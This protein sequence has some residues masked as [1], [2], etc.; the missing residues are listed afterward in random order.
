MAAR[1]LPPRSQGRHR[2][3]PSG[4][5]SC[6]PI[7]RATKSSSALPTPAS[8]SG[9]NSDGVLCG[10]SANN[11]AVGCG[12][13]GYGAENSYGH[14]DTWLSPAGSYG[15]GSSAA[16]VSVRLSSITRPSG[17]INVVDASYYGA[18]PDTA[19]VTG[20]EKNAKTDGDS[21]CAANDHNCSDAA[22][23]QFQG[24]QY[25]SYWKNLGNANWSWGD[26]TPTNLGGT[27]PDAAAPALIQQ[28]HFQTLNCLFADGHVKAMQWSQVVGDICLWAT[29][30][31]GNH[32]ACQ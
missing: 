26:G 32:P 11:S 9:T 19:N 12:G 25:Q 2:I 29:D 1:I 20:L 5:H 7:L 30:I 8:W 14:N 23:Q 27:L 22:F 24:G 4:P 28:R 17:I 18:G 13:F 6:S 3:E 10:N 31:N 15:G 16:P 21:P